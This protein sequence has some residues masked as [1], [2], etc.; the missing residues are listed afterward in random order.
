M[1][2]IL[3]TP[4]MRSIGAKELYPGPDVTTDEEIVRHSLNAGPYGYHTLGTAAIGPDDDDVV[5]E[6]LRVRGVDGLRVVDASVFPYQ[7]SGNNGP[8]SPAAW[9]AADLI[10]E[11]AKQYERED[12][13]IK[14]V[15]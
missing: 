5:D 7:P 14:A 10:L 9:I 8:T 6:R 13:Q 3:D 15:G 11:D 4:E 2:A 12:L 1:R